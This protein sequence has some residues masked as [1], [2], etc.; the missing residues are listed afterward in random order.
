M[1]PLRIAIFEHDPLAASEIQTAV[2]DAGCIICGIF[3]DSRAV[4]AIYEEARPDLAVI[5]VSLMA[6]EM[7]SD[8]ANYLRNKGCEIVVFPCEQVID[9]IFCRIS[10]SFISRAQSPAMATKGSR[11]SA[12]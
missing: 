8:L 10:H 1:R 6:G 7:G 3:R 11:P 12:F 5:D 9:P 4:E 2:E